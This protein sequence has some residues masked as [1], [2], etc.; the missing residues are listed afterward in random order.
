M[1]PPGTECK[2]FQDPKEEDLDEAVDYESDTNF[3]GP[4]GS[5]LTILP[6]KMTL[7]VN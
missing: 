2:T 1:A 4:N 3:M 6:V 5:P 7:V